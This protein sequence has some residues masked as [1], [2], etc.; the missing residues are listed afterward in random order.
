MAFFTQCG[1]KNDE[2]AG[3]CESCGRALDERR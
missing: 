2:G 3:F 1:A